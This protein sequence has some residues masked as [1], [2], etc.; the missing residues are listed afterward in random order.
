MYL[1]FSLMPK[2]PNGGR[3]A[4]AT[5]R[6]LTLGNGKLFGSP[7]SA[8]IAER[9]ACMRG[10]GGSLTNESSA[11]SMDEI[12]QAKFSLTANLKLDAG[13]A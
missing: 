8:T 1:E 10:L 5:E 7:P 2:L 3:Q 6:L 11:K 12:L 9:V 4:R 13:L